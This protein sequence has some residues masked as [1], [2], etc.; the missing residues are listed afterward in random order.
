METSPTPASIPR[1]IA[2]PQGATGLTTGWAAQTVG[3]YFEAARIPSCADASSR[4]LIAQ[5]RRLSSSSTTRSRKHYWPGQDPIGKRIHLGVKKA[6]C[7]GDRR[8]RDRRYSRKPAPI[9]PHARSSISLPDNSK[10]PLVLSLGICSEAKTGTIVLRSSLPPD[11]MK[12]SLL[13]V[14]RSIDRQLPLMQ[15]ES[16]DQ[17][18]V[19]AVRRRG[20]SI[21]PSLPVLPPPLCCLL[22]LASTR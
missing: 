3:Y 6:R 9:R 15:V 8:R 12:D 18:V 13:S 7:L 2:P 4:T 14:V 20:V 22:C 1:A 19:R 11:A 16:M 21:R 10:R 17:V 5:A